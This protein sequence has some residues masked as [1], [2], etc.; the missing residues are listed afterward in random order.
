MT[1]WSRFAQNFLILVLQV[2]C[3]RYNFGPR[4]TR[5]VGHPNCSLFMLDRKQELKLSQ[6]TFIAA[7]ANE[8][9]K[10][11]MQ[12]LAF[13]EVKRKYSF[14]DVNKHSDRIASC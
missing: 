13:L 10:T 1:N 4:Q 9:Y 5:M 2:L 14:T 12:F 3:P 11:L 7:T 8:K 6:V